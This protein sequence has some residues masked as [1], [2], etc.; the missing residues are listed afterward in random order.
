MLRSPTR[1]PTEWRLLIEE[2]NQVTDDVALHCFQ[3]RRP[4]STISITYRMHGATTVEDP[5]SGVSQFRG[6]YSGAAVYTSRA[7]SLLG[8][9][10][11]KLSHM[12]EAGTAQSFIS[13]IINNADCV[14]FGCPHWSS[15]VAVGYS[16]PSQRRPIFQVGRPHN[17]P[18]YESR[19]ARRLQ[20]NVLSHSH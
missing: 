11:I 2:S 10:G 13:D 5:S 3:D 15:V 17:F 18:E 7:L 20:Q 12:V 4:A 9:R 14:C 1:H 6:D 19:L 8:P 16:K